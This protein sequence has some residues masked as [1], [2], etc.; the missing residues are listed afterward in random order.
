[1]HQRLLHQSAALILAYDVADNLLQARWAPEQTLA[2]GKEL[3]RLGP[4][5]IL[6]WRIGAGRAPGAAGWL[7]VLH[8]Y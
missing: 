5:S 4:S 1:M 8:Y 3:V 6:S 2:T 7:I